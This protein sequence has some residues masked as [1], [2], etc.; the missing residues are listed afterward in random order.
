MYADGSKFEPKVASALTEH[1]TIDK[2]MIVVFFTAGIEAINKT[3]KYVKVSSKK[4]L[5]IF[6][7][8]MSV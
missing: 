3:L 5:V 7:D 4:R 2:E 8:T 1:G 6:S